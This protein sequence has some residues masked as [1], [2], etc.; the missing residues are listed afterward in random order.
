MLARDEARI[1]LEV[2]SGRS[3]IEASEI[4]DDLGCL[5]LAVRQIAALIRRLNLDGAEVRRLLRERLVAAPSVSP[6]ARLF[7]R[8]GAPMVVQ[9]CWSLSI[10]AADRVAPGAA[11]MLAVLSCFPPEPHQP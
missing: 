3:V 9:T 5:P 10:E 1:L 2:E 6:D 8:A 4:V 7:R 11:H